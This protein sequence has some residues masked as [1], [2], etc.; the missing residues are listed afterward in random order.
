MLFMDLIFELPSCAFL[1]MA[2]KRFVVL[3]NHSISNLKEISQST[4][5]FDFQWIKSGLRGFDIFFFFLNIGRCRSLWE[6]LVSNQVSFFEKTAD[7]L[8]LVSGQS[9]LQTKS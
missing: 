5:K 4:I 6:V 9:V 8:I 7:S 1:Q 3:A 2:E